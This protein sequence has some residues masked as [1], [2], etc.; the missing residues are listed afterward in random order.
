MQLPIHSA[1]TPRHGALFVCF[2][3][4]III[5]R[6]AICDDEIVAMNEENQNVKG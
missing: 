5:C 6:T 1:T 3:E 4:T 2:V